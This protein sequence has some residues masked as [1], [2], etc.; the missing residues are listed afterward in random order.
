MVECPG[1]LGTASWTQKLGSC[2]AGGDF[3]QGHHQ[4]ARMVT[5]MVA[6]KGFSGPRRDSPCAGMQAPDSALSLSPAGER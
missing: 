3:M 2:G 6:A 4:L 5:N 1:V